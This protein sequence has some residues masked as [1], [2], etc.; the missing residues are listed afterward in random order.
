M[1]VPDSPGA[2]LKISCWGD[3]NENLIISELVENFQ[4]SHPGLKVSLQWINYFG[5]DD[6]LLK[7]VKAGTAP[8]V[9]FVSSDDFAELFPKRVLEPL[10]SFVQADPDFQSGDFYP[11]LIERFTVGGQLY[12]IPRDI[13]PVCLMYYNQQAFRDAGLP[14]PTETWNWDQFLTAAKALTL[15][16]MAE[17]TLR[18]GYVEDWVMVEPWVYSN[19]A[20][21]VDSPQR[22]AQYRFNDPAFI[23][24]VQYRA[25]LSLKHKVMP[26]P[27]ELAASGMEP[28]ELFMKGG[29]A[30][31]LSGLWKTP[32]LRE[33][34]AFPWDVAL[35]PKGPNGHR[36]FASG[37]SGYG[38]L[39]GSG[40]K[41]AA[42]E[43]I[44]HLTGAEGEKKMAASGLAQPALTGVAKSPAFLDKRPPLN[45]KILVDSE[46]QGVFEP[47]AANWRQL[48]SQFIVP[49]LGPVW[50][51]K[52]TA[53]EA[54]LELDSLLKGNPLQR[55]T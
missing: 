17:K 48:R 51:G 25:D 39:K 11:S 47:F 10:G 50:T 27:G 12:V 22:P 45:K 52:R 32:P 29:A 30:I 26:G 13:S 23:Q 38:I 3:I 42:W 37:G 2:T 9:V 6:F 15:R 4:E 16:D 34:R 31:Y 54:I 33:N 40:Q 36:G 24:A 43:L 21:W 20:R 46:P 28:L 8:D 49:A 5:Y 7:E 14:F 41:K 1:N 19:G 18:W 53:Q 55:P 35:V 44:R